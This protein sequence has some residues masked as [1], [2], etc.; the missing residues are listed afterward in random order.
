VI[1]DKVFISY[2]HKDEKWLQL[3]LVHLKPL[4]KKGLNVWSDKDIL[5]GQ[6][7]PSEI[8]NSLVTANVA[9]LL[10]S[11]EFLASDFIH[12]KEVPR[13]LGPAK[14]GQIEI[15]PV[16]ISAC[17]WDETEIGKYQSPIDYKKPLKDLRGNKRD[18]ALVSIAKAIKAAW[19]K[20]SCSRSIPEEDE[21]R[22]A[23]SDFRKLA[24]QHAAM[25]ADMVQAC[26]RRAVRDCHGDTSIED[27]FPQLTTLQALGWPQLND[28]F[29]ERCRPD[30]ALVQALERHINSPV[31]QPLTPVEASSYIALVLQRSGSQERDTR[32]YTWS[33]FVAE[34]GRD[35]YQEPIVVE[36]LEHLR[37]QVVFDQ[38]LENETAIA[39]VLHHLLAW[40]NRIPRLWVLEI[41]APTELLDA[42][43]S[44]LV[45]EDDNDEEIPLLESIAYVLRPL[46][47]LEESLN[48][49]RMR[50]QRKIQTLAQGK[51]RWCV[52]DDAMNTRYL[53]SVLIE[54]DHH[55]ALKRSQPLPEDER[56]RDFWF[57]AL[58]HSM[59][60]IA[61]WFRHGTKGSEDDWSTHLNS[62]KLLSGH[63]D[64]TQACE[65]C[66]N[67]EASARQR[68]Q[69]CLQPLAKQVV[70]MLDHW[71]RTPK[72]T[73]RDRGATR[74]TSPSL[75]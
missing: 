35:G 69:L 12:D 23:L 14:L 7:W 13:F 71:E 53:R 48:A 67:Y 55:V 72:I 30:P 19:V 34:D 74:A 70:F 16:L 17:A 62:Y 38:P 31:P 68:K 57:A 2:S 56:Q 26:F 40:A 28:F 36:S 18:E 47:R 75:S 73:P 65:S 24:D 46:D 51:G 64:G 5:P 21:S 1:R 22:T 15:L 42:P 25:T 61:I 37:N 45:V 20:Q 60:P 44:E 27:L 33:A 41:F 4:V 3:L 54:Q 49:K 10:V 58:I 8:E 59:V 63:E 32:Y 66:L 11:A 29:N 43:W 39:T 52:G 9:V 50:L 6:Q